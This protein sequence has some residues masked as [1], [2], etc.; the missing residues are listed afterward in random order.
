MGLVII[1][2]RLAILGGVVFGIVFGIVYARRSAS[3][4]KR[5]E[6]I[7]DDLLALKAG[8]ENGVYDRPEFDALT[9]D[10]YRKCEEEG[11]DVPRL[12]APSE[13]SP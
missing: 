6:G 13:K 8:L 5:M 7:R 4:R 2:L 3:Q 1:L 11:I 10:I 9:A 12:E